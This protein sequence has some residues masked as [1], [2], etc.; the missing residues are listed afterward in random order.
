MDQDGRWLL[1]YALEKASDRDLCEIAAMAK[2][3]AERQAVFCSGCGIRIG[4]RHTPECP[5]G[6]M[7]DDVSTD[8]VLDVAE[9]I[10]RR[11]LLLR[12][13]QEIP[14]MRPITRKVVALRPDLWR[15]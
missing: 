15:E 4:L 9:E 7:G 3:L 11:V 1:F 10:E 2:V 5:R 13:G 8:D 14:S 6:E 12:S